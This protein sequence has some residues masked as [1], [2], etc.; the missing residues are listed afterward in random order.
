LDWR[1]TAKKKTGKK[2]GRNTAIFEIK[3]LSQ[4][5]DEA[6]RMEEADANPLSRFCPHCQD[7]G[8]SF[9]HA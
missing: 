1:A 2:A 3:L 9:G 4:I 6:V 7:T 8:R 5:M